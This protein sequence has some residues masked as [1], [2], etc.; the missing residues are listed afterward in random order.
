MAVGGRIGNASAGKETPARHKKGGREHEGA[1]CCS[2]RSLCLRAAV[3]GKGT[4]A[5]LHGNPTTR[6][7][8]KVLLTQPDSTRPCSTQRSATQLSSTQLQ[9]T[10]LN[11][12]QHDSAQLTPP[13]PNQSKIKA[14][15]PTSARL[16]PAYPAS[17]RP[18][19]TPLI[20]CSTQ[21]NS[22]E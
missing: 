20:T 13:S 22:P 19:S 18:N 12:A 21:Y 2:V 15:R 14:T 7:A 17:P 6:M 10:E 4:H 8:G 1:R 9:P 16:N 11:L 3:T 5:P